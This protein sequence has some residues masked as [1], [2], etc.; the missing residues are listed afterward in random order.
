MLAA[1][2]FLLLGLTV[3][4]V[5]ALIVIMEATLPGWPPAITIASPS[6][7]AVAI[8]QY[9]PEYKKVD[10][11]VLIDGRSHSLVSV[12]VP[13]GVIG[14]DGV[15]IGWNGEHQLT[16]GWPIGATPVS[17]PKSVGGID[18]SYRVYNPDLS[19]APAGNTR[20]ISRGPFTLPI[21]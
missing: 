6:A 18:V 14:D 2:V 4:A 1:S 19:K 13:W 8:K 20:N 7:S 3:V 5:L 17:G 21:Q 15:T 10:V 9:D 12:P 11:N 16:L